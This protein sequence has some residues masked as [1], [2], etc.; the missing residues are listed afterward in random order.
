NNKEGIIYGDPIKGRMMIL[1]THDGG[2]T[3]LEL[4]ESNRP[5]LVEGEAS[6]AASGT[7]I[8]CLKNNKVIIATGGKVS[9]LLSSNNKGLKWSSVNTPIIHGQNSTGIFSFAFLN[10]KTGII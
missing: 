4:P 1:R 7:S 10:E 8:R 6:F 3:W 5:V 2:L 9:G